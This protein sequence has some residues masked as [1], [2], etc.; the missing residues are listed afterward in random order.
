MELVLLPLHENE[1]NQF[2]YFGHISNGDFCY[3]M[4][5]MYISQQNT[6]KMLFLVQ[7]L[8][9]GDVSYCTASVLLL[10]LGGHFGYALSWDVFFAFLEA[11]PTSHR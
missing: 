11:I 5:L 2:N 9:E 8:W 1:K 3:L 4:R 7:I 6:K 10:Q